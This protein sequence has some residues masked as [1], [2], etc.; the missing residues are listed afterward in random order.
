[1]QGMKVQITGLRES[2]CCHWQHWGNV[3]VSQL[4]CVPDL[5]LILGG[6]ARKC[7][8]NMYRRGTETVGQVQDRSIDPGPVRH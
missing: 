7:E 8:V 3:T 6:S 2:H 1:M 5:T 4:Q